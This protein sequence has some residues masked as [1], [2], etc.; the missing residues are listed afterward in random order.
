MHQ[1]T[2]YTK[3][4]VT[5]I[6]QDPTRRRLRYADTTDYAVPRT[7]TNFDERAFCVAGPST[8]NSVRVSEKD[9]KLS[10]RHLTL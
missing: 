9:F 2:S 10:E 4:A 3:D 5:P 1:T 6:S 8:W 7:W